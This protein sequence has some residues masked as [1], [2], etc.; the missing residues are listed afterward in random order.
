MKKIN[1]Y[2]LTIL[3]VVFAS[4]F[5][6]FG[7]VEHIKAYDICNPSF[8]G[9]FCSTD[10]EC[11]QSGQTRCVDNLH[12][13]ICGRYGSDRRLKWSPLKSCLGDTSC[14]YDKCKDNERPHW[15]CFDGNCRYD[16]IYDKNCA[17]SSCQCDSGACCDG[18]NYR[19]STWICA[20]G[21]KI[22][23]G[24]PWGLS[25]GSDVGVRVK[26]ELRY[27]SGNSSNCDGKIVNLG[28]SDWKVADSCSPNEVCS[29]GNK[30]CHYSSS[31]K[32]KTS[33]ILTNTEKR[34][35]ISKAKKTK[36]FAISFLG[37]EGGSSSGW[38]K[39]VEVGF[40]KNIDFLLIIANSGNKEL[41]NLSLNITFPKGIKYEDD[42]KI[43][44]VPIKKD[45]SN[46]L[47]LDSI[48]S[49]VIKTITF[50]ATESSVPK[51]G[52][53]NVL[54]EAKKENLSVSDSIKISFK[55]FQNQEANAMVGLKSFFGK[56][57]NWVLAILGV[58]VLS[59]F[60]KGI[61]NWF[62]E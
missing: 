60:I 6:L 9:F 15:Y 32:I 21:K 25:C 61:L 50:K 12:R 2:F 18:C 49:N 39:D 10:N 5:F 41:K 47:K 34:N 16:C 44:G 55:K 57:Y 22:Q 38:N 27:C 53:E 7:V 23:Y 62:K 29:V 1:S 28:W 43:D 4:L 13:E 51:N 59:S 20:T 56:W 54:V 52:E 58:I 42:L 45:F 30:F 26:K 14:G 24:C 3:V 31:C 36:Y 46:G 17:L 35:Y 19:P 37:K 11:S 48:P 33:Q 40:G 8:H